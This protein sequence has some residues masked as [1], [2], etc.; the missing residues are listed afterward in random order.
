MSA[1]IDMV[2]RSNC[3]HVNGLPVWQFIPFRTHSSALAFT[4]EYIMRGHVEGAQRWYEKRYKLNRQL[5]E[6]TDTPA[7]RK[8]LFASCSRLGDIEKDRNNLSRA[9]GWYEESLKITG[10]CTYCGHCKPCPVNIDIAMVNKFYDLAK[11]S[12]PVD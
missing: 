1:R 12:Q 5:A 2:T 11:H 4:R 3:G 6:E 10:Q 8:D 7:S 9:K